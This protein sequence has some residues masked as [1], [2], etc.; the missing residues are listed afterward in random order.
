MI[1]GHG[2]A[3]A[4]LLPETESDLPETRLS[5]ARE[6]CWREPQC[7]P[8]SKCVFGG[9]RPWGW[10]AWQGPAHRGRGCHTGCEPRNKPDAGAVQSMGFGTKLAPVL[11]RREPTAGPRSS[12][13]F[14]QPRSLHLRER[15]VSPLR[16]RVHGRLLD[17]AT[18]HTP[19]GYPD[20]GDGGTEVF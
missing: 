19:C 10:V 6:Q 14:S 12:P 4:Y 7:F 5:D 17:R 13:H 11:T 3:S 18:L 9:G 2:S 15:G 8:E 16:G 20:G 1:W